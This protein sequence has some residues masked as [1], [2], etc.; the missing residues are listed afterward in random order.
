MSDE[1]VFSDEVVALSKEIKESYLNDNKFDANELMSITFNLMKLVEN[2]KVKYS[3]SDKKKVVLLLVRG[4]IIEV[5]NSQV[6]EDIK[7][8]LL[9]VVD[10]VLPTVIDLLVAAVNGDLKLTTA[11][12]LSRFMCSCCKPKTV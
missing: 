10:N 2:Y 4:M 3:G 9:F 7:Q 11:S 8:S 6:P 5:D 1:K 12:L